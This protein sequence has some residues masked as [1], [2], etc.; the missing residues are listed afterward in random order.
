MKWF[1]SYKRFD[2]DT[3]SGYK[4][5]ITETYTSFDEIEINALE[6][7]LR[8]AIGSGIITESEPTGAE[9]SEKDEGDG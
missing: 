7:N 5:V 6:R 3:V 9:G 2:P 1:V 4:I 8:Q